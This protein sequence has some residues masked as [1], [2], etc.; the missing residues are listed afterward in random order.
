[1]LLCLADLQCYPIGCESGIDKKAQRKLI[2]ASVLCLLF[3]LMEIAGG[4]MAN[5][6]AIATD[7][8]HL[9]TDFASYMISLLA[10]WVAARPATKEMSFGWHRAEVIGATVSVLL[11]WYRVIHHQLI[12]C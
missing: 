3:M 6:L 9:L 11:L 2:I 12:K 5:S 1:M 7:A 4:F 8:A 10:I